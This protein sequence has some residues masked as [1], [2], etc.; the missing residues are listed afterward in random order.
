MDLHRPERREDALES[1]AEVSRIT[2]DKTGTLTYG[3]PEV[4]E[5]FSISEKWN[6]NEIYRLTAAAEKLSEHPLGKAVISCWQK[7]ERKEKQLPEAEGFAMVPGKGIS[8]QVE[9]K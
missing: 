3:T 4:I 5:V 8:C 1:L 2:F 9:G 7:E 6:E